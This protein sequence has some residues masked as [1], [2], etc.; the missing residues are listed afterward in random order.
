MQLTTVYAGLYPNASSIVTRF[1]LN[2]IIP[3]LQLRKQGCRDAGNLPRSHSWG[4]R[5][6]CESPG[7]WALCSQET[8]AAQTSHRPRSTSKRGLKTGKKETI[9]QKGS[10]QPSECLGFRVVRVWTKF[11]RSKSLPL[12]FYPTGI[13]YHSALI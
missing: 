10:Q 5:T 12:F 6:R 3:I 2:T 4:G 8:A 9:L 13:P 7:N 1:V 11:P